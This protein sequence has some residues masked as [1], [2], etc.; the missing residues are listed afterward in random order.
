MSKDPQSFG[1]D[2]TSDK[3]GRVRDYLIHYKQALKN[4]PFQ[5][6]YIDAFAGTGYNIPKKHRDT[7]DLLLPEFSEQ[8]TLKFI[9]GSATIALRIEP[10]FDK[11]IFIEQHRKRFTE[12]QK[13]KDEFPSHNIEVVK[14]DANEYIKS[15]CERQW[16]LERAVLFLDPFGMQVTWDTIEAIAGT[17]AIDLWLLFPLGVAVNRLLKKDAQIPDMW[18]QKLDA[19]FGETSWYDVFYETTPV[20]G[21]FGEEMIT[22]KTGTFD[23]ISSYFV[24]RLKTVFP[25]VAENPLPLVSSNNNPLYLLCFAAANPKGAPIAVKI[26]QH[27][28]RRK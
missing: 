4:Q 27:I 6:I 16:R 8:E 2:W 22:R 23:S 24:N 20:P 12:L 26:A 13:L 18:R 15:I 5:L 14:A 19:M 11:Y 28:L 25:K 17:K 21:L 1:G 10:P 7:Q 3:L 9:E